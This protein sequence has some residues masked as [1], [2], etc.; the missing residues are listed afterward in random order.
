MYVYACARANVVYRGLEC[1]QC[2]GGGRVPSLLDVPGVSAAGWTAAHL[3]K[4]SGSTDRDRQSLQNRLTAFLKTIFDKI[5]ALKDS[6]HFL[7]PLNEVSFGGMYCS[8]DRLG[9]E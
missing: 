6:K 2:P 7:S 9:L 4:G 8:K 5:K 3:Y 1:A